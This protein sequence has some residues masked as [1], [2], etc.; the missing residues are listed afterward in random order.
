[1]ISKDVDTPIWGFLCICIIITSGNCVLIYC[2]CEIALVQLQYQSDDQ[3]HE[4]DV[5]RDL[6]NSTDNESRNTMASN[7]EKPPLIA[8]QTEK[9]SHNSHSSLNQSLSDMVDFSHLNDP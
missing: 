5:I 6:T 7:F 2:L 8:R 1:M 3:Q 4:T 9:L